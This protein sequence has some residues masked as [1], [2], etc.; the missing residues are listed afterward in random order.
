M[1]LGLK[2]Y[3]WF[4]S[5]KD[6]STPDAQSLVPGKSVHSIKEQVKE[7]NLADKDLALKT[8]GKNGSD[9][10]DAG[11][12]LDQEKINTRLSTKVTSIPLKVLSDVCLKLNLKR[13]LRFD[14]FRMLAEKVGLSRD[15]TEY[16]E[17][18]FL[19]HTEEIL[20]TWSK[21]REA[22]VGKLIEI[23]KEEDF[24]RTDVTDI[25]ENWVY[26]V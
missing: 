6:G 1:H 25:L 3:F 23:L 12:R 20:K 22:T 19:N 10:V 11:A 26:E 7:M 21:K 17:Q 16:I 15:E 8:R 2:C 9:A 13:S 4:I 14:D 24:D 5:F 18:K